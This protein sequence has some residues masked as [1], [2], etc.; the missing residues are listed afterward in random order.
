MQEALQK[1]YLE[2]KCLN[3]REKQLGVPKIPRRHY[4]KVKFKQT[5]ILKFETK[6]L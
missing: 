1:L 5:L 6:R 2:C 3:E 4:H